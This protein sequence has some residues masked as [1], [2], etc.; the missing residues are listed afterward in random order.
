VPKAVDTTISK[1]ANRSVIIRIQCKVIRLGTNEMN[2]RT[3]KKIASYR[4][5]GSKIKSHMIAI[6]L[7]I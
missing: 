7:R 1:M 5:I 3:R 6:L 4:L 2:S